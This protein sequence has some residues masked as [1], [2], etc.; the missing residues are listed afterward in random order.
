ML[1]FLEEVQFLFYFTG[2]LDWHWEALGSRPG[3][4]TVLC[5]LADCFKPSQCLSL[6]TQEYKCVLGGRVRGRLPVMNKHPFKGGGGGGKRASNIFSCF[7]LQKISQGDLWQYGPLY[8][9]GDFNFITVFL[10]FFYAFQLDP[11]S[12]R[13]VLVLKTRF[14]RMYKMPWLR[15]KMASGRNFSWVSHV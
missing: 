5:S 15:K 4:V 14:G 8:V 12:V 11:R 3:Q 7:M 13:W 10:F 9:S 6:S 2:A 1:N